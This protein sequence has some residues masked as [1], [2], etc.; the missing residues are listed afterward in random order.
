METTVAPRTAPTTHRWTREQYERMVE[1]GVLGEDDRVELIEGK[2][3]TTSPQGSQQATSV[4][5][6]ADALQE[7]YSDGV[8]IRVQMPLALGGRSEP[9]PDIAVIEGRRRDYADAHP[10][11][12]L[13]VVEVSDT[14]GPFDRTQKQALYARHGIGTYWIVDLDREHLEVYRNPSGEQY[15][16]KRTVHRG[17]S[18][19]PPEGDET[20]AVTDLLP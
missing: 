10:T 15:E 8:F 19:T 12:A 9:E 14:S 20:V 4:G 13:L 2:I 3:V 18:V 7:V 5:L 1:A 6:I 11:T 16:E 17:E